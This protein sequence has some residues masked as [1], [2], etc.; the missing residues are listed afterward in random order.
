MRACHTWQLSKP[1]TNNCIYQA[2]SL[3]NWLARL[4]LTDSSL[5][6][7]DGLGAV[8]W[9]KVEAHSDAVTHHG[10]RHGTVL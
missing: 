7:V 8:R 2:P 5:S 9:H 10:A 3:L 6:P 1:D 4:R